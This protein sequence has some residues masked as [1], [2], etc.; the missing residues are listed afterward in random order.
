MNTLI[1]AM[2]GPF[3]ADLT[4]ALLHTLWQGA[5]LAAGLYLLLKTVVTRTGLRYGLAV[6]AL[7]LIALCPMLTFGV[8]NCELPAAPS[9][10]LKT[11]AAAEPP[12][13]L[14][15]G[16]ASPIDLQTSAA[17]H[18]SAGS[19]KAADW[20]GP[21]ICL[22]LAGVALMLVRAGWMVYGASRLKRNCTP[23]N[24]PRLAA[25]LDN[26]REKM[27]IARRV[28][29]AAVD[30]I[31]SPAV[32]GFIRP[33]ILLPLSM[34]SGMAT[35]DIEAILAHELAHIKRFDCLVNFCQMVVE[36]LLFFNPAAWWVSRQIRIEREACCDAA[37][38][39]MTGQKLGYAQ[40]LYTWA[41][42]LSNAPK[43]AAAAMIAFGEKADDGHML[44]RIQR[45]VVTGHRPRMRISAAMTLAMMAAAAVLLIGLWHG[46]RAGV[47]L[48]GRILTPAERIEKMAEIAKTHG[49]PAYD[50]QADRELTD[51]EKV[52]LSGIVRTWDGLPLPNQTHLTVHASRPGHGISAAIGIDRKEPGHATFSTRGSYGVIYISAHAE[53]YSPFF[54]G[55]FELEPGDAKNDIE[56]LF[57]KPAYAQ[58]QIVDAET[59]QAV[60]GVQLSGG[61]VFQPSGWHYTIGVTTDAQGKARIAYVENVPVTLRAT[62]DAYEHT[63]FEKIMLSLT[64]PLVLT[65]RKALP[66]TG[67]V[68]SAAAGEPVAGAEI[69]IQRKSDPHGVSWGRDQ[70]DIVGTT[71]PDGR[72]TITSLNSESKYILAFKADGFAYAFL[73]GVSAGDKD[74]RIALQNEIIIKG[75][76]V[77][78][79][80]DLP[81]HKGQTAVSYACGYEHDHDSYWDVTQYAPVIETED[82]VSFEIRNI[83][84]NRL[85][86]GADRYKER[87]NLD[88]D[89]IPE[90]LVINLSEQPDDIPGAKRGVVI[91]FNVPQGAPPVRGRIRVTTLAPGKQ[92]STGR[93]VEIVDNRAQTELFAP[94][95]LSIQLA[96]TVGYWFGEQHGLEVDVAEEPYVARIDVVPAGTI[97]GE[98]FEHDGGPAGNTMVSFATVEQS[99]LLPKNAHFSGVEGK[100]SASAAERQTK[101]SVQP[102]PLGGKYRIIAHRHDSY[103]VSET[104]ALTEEQPIRQVDLV[105]PRGVRLTG[106]VLQPDGSPAAGMEYGLSFVA[107]KAGSFGWGPRFTDSQGRFTCENVN[108]NA[109]G[110]YILTVKSNKTWRPAQIDI[111]DFE[112]EITVTLAEGAVAVGRIVDNATGWPIPG[113]Q[114]RAWCY[115]RF[116]N[117]S[118][119]LN[120]EAETDNDGRFRFSTMKTGRTY[121]LNTGDCRVV[122][123]RS[124]EIVGGRPDETTI[125]VTLYD[126]SELKP[127]KPE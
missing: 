121:N 52:T 110:R 84:G 108:P 25:M 12:V 86:V 116:T 124:P 87:F 18:Q 55:P 59:G 57:Q 76:I 22:W 26:L 14:P 9:D 104:I 106:Q 85:N 126:W 91:E 90:L 114:V 28:G 24:D 38:V 51:E 6:G 60:E 20:H 72:F 81:T 98:V 1:D 8:L 62:A 105:F 37:S 118:E 112:K 111:K 31:A 33:T 32:V 74:I 67:V 78:P 95:K 3:A 101:Y 70:G 65:L 35:Q 75:R 125:K 44:D 47:E 89:S 109:D 29:V 61:H 16:P 82:G 45:I 43:T 5:A 4:A 66:T 123:P 39:L 19:A 117:E 127:R 2:S 49:Q 69:R 92:Y 56:V 94:C 115:D 64:E 120:A 30:R 50:P 17:P 122:E 102:L 107:N 63:Q 40:L 58:F 97:F 11:S 71:G 113:V 99:P 10:H 54:A 15:S 7:G 83:W 93:L 103:A 100:N 46:A 77:G 80:D 96:D 21:A 68:V 53:G 42:R 13:A 27:R 36:A 23:V 119:H 73:T 34:M 88:R 48:A 41:V 79:L